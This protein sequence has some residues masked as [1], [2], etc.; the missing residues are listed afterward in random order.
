M[1]DKDPHAQQDAP[2]HKLRLSRPQRLW[3]LLKASLDPRA[4]AHLIKMVN[5]YNYTHV[6]PLRQIR[7]G[8]NPS[9]S[10]TAAFSYP[11]RIRIG[12]RVRIGFRCVI[13]AGPGKGRVILGDDVLLG[14]EVMITASGYRYND[15]AP[16]TDQA[17]DEADVVIGN[18]VWLGTRVTVL[19]GA[20][21]GDG[22]IIGAHSVVRGDIPA[23]A[24]AVGSPARVVSQRQIQG[25][26]LKDDPQ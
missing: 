18:D 4:W 8:A 25:A 15:G 20:R 10:P 24:I 12:A 2:A 13:W 16:I 1:I 3:R 5:F 6:A 26:S 9:I 7:L 19:P 23:M 22:A 17:S 14:P 11:E 21:I